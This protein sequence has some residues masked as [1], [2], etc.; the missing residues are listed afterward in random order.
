MSLDLRPYDDDTQSTAPIPLATAP[1]RTLLRFLVA[2]P[3]QYNELTEILLSQHWDT[4]SPDDE[5]YI[6]TLPESGL[7]AY[8]E[9]R[10]CDAMRLGFPFAAYNELTR[11][12]A[13]SGR[14]DQPEYLVALRHLAEEYGQPDALADLGCF[15]SKSWTLR[16]GLQVPGNRERAVHYCCRAA[17]LGNVKGMRNLGDLMWGHESLSNSALPLIHLIESSS[18]AIPGH[19]AGK[20]ERN[21]AWWHLAHAKGRSGPKDLGGWACCATDETIP[22]DRLLEFHSPYA[23]LVAASTAETFDAAKHTEMAVHHLKRSLDAGY[24]DAYG[25]A[26]KS[27]FPA[28]SP[29]FHAKHKFDFLVRQLMACGVPQGPSLAGPSDPPGDRYPWREE[30]VLAVPQSEEGPETTQWTPAWYVKHWQDSL[31]HKN[32]IRCLWHVTRQCLQLIARVKELQTIRGMD[33]DT[34][35]FREVLE[36]L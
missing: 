1:F 11:F 16:N 10:Y 27:F 6:A 24:R 34:T 23:H 13:F 30:H 28:E 14:Y 22:D 8:L 19:D 20:G 5:S 7:K 32:A 3:H 36:H 2:H 35:I 31:S 15:F 18:R 17:A 21:L 9:S 26:L 4:Q 12:W 33:Q 29:V 25:M